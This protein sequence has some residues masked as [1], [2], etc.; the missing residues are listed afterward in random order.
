MSSD[1]PGPR[2]S[3]CGATATPSSADCGPAAVAVAKPHGTSSGSMKF[4]RPS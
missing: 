4:G 1:G 2:L 3:E